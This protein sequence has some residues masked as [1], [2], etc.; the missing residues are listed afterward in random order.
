MSTRI[1]VPIISG[2]VLFGCAN[3]LEHTIENS[4]AAFEKQHQAYRYLK[5]EEQGVHSRYQLEPAGNRLQTIAVGS[6]VLLSDIFRGLNQKC[7]FEK[8]DLVETRVVSHQHPRYY[9]VWV[10][11]D[12]LSERADKKSAVSV[13]LDVYPNNGGTD[14]SFSGS[15]HAKPVKLVF[16]K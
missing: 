4:N 5:V 9:E 2:I 16:A 8:S 15:C 6:T 10:F 7:G 1:F 12:V 13:V 14:I 11:N 3:P